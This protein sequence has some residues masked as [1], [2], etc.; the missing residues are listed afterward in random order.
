MEKSIFWKLVKENQKRYELQN[1]L[2]GYH[3]DRPIG[4]GFL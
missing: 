3:F 1:D 4:P 2:T